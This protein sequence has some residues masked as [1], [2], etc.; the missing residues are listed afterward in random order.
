MLIVARWSITDCWKT[1]FSALRCSPACFRLTC[2]SASSALMSSM[3]RLKASRVLTMRR[4]FSSRSSLVLPA[5]LIE[6]SVE[7][8]SLLQNS[9]LADSSF[10]WLANSTNILS[11]TSFTFEKASSPVRTAR[12]TKAQ[13]WCLRATAAIFC[14]ARSM[15]RSC[16]RA[17]SEEAL[18]DE[19]LSC[20]KVT[21]FPK[22][23]LDSSSVR[24]LMVSASA[25]TSSLRVLERALYC[26][27]SDLQSFCMLA[28][29]P[30]SASMAAVV[31]SR[32]SLA[33][34]AWSRVSARSASLDS[35]ALLPTSISPSLAALRLWKETSASKSCFSAEA[36]S[37]VNWSLISARRP[38]M[39]PL[40]EL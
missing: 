4:C 37:A 9:F 26:S 25:T 38:T 14:I 6:S 10:C 32:S 33:F 27:S 7:S 17:A 28:R 3:L 8:R 15:A 2:I 12:E 16:T 20:S 39:P 5:T 35:L 34:A 31:D 30:W 24:I 22:R 11:M 1:W 40:L 13:F 21:D 29:K 36:K 19:P 18:T 23:S